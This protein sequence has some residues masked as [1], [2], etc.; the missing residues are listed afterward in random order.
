MVGSISEQ[1][2]ASYPIPLLL[3]FIF[4]QTLYLLFYTPT[5]SII[6]ISNIYYNMEP[7][8]I[9]LYIG[10]HV[11]LAL[12]AIGVCYWS[13]NVTILHVCIT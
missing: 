13:N 9:G 11:L 12:L 8:Y 3:S 4:V 1:F 7:L 5:C 6:I 2:N 10:E